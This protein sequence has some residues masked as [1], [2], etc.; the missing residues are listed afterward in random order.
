MWTQGKA[1]LHSNPTQVAKMSQWEHL[2]KQAALL[3][4]SRSEVLSAEAAKI[5]QQVV[6][7]WLNG[8]ASVASELNAAIFAQTD[9]WSIVDLAVFNEALQASH[10]RTARH[11]AHK[12]EEEEVNEPGPSALD[13]LE[14]K[15]KELDQQVIGEVELLY[16]S[17]VAKIRNHLMPEY[18][19]RQLLKKRKETLLTDRYNESCKVAQMFLD[20]NILILEYD[21]ENTGYEVWKQLEAAMFHAVG[22]A[23]MP[24]F[25]ALAN[26]RIPTSIPQW[27]H[28][29]IAA[30]TSHMLNNS[31][32]TNN[33]CAVILAPEYPPAGHRIEDINLVNRLQSK[34]VCA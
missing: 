23:D 24:R 9:S 3:V 4:A 7:D 1:L 2:A 33:T 13:K 32:D 17:E 8:S 20:E 19:L 18:E 22:P 26:F 14:Q 25:L 31:S 34:G 16:N 15:Q 10:E 6:D 12:E 29:L 27:E 28:E 21:Q 5:L 11:A 30:L